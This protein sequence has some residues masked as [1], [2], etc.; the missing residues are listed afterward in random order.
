MLP[1]TVAHTDLPAPRANKAFHTDWRSE[2]NASGLILE[3]W[4]EGF[5]VGCLVVMA[6][7]TVANMRRGIL[8]HKLILLEVSINIYPEQ[9]SMLMIVR[10]A[11][12]RDTSRD[13]LL[14][15][16][17]GPRLVPLRY[18]VAALHLLHR[19]QHRCLDQDQTV[20]FDGRVLFGPR[21]AHIVSRVYLW[22]LALSWVPNLLQIVCNFL[23]FNGIYNL[24]ERIRPTEFLFRCVFSK[25]ENGTQKFAKTGP[26]I[27]GG[28]SRASRCSMSYESAMAP[29][30]LNLSV[31]ARD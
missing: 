9:H 15:D 23:F 10:L 14:Y 4:G 13:L 6:C 27:H 26:E 18:S 30:Y 7:V 28:S 29:A 19:P 17:P 20:R 12:P 31:G 16:L 21:A 22:T 5:L 11:P 3:A 8:L 24:Y 25:G 2:T 1:S